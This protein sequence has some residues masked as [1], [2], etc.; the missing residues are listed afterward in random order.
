MKQFGRCCGYHHAQFCTST[1]RWY[2]NKTKIEI[3]FFMNIKIPS[4]D[5]KRRNNLQ[6]LD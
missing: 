4:L 1:F 5:Q 3:A 2:D 6:E